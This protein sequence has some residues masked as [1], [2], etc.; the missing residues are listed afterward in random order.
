MADVRRA[1]LLGSARVAAA[2]AVGR[3][4]RERH[5]T[6]GASPAELQLGLAAVRFVAG[7][8]YGCKG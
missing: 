5:A 2:I 6:R 8:W 3:L 1:E 7:G 4:Q